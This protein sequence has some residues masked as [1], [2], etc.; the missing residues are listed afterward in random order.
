[1]VRRGLLALIV[2][3]IGSMMLFAGLAAASQ[4]T[5]IN[6]ANAPSGTHLQ[7]GTIG[8]SVDATTQLV[9]CNSF[10]LNGV[11]NANAIGSLVATYSA[12]VN[13]TNHGGNLVPVKSSAQSAPTTTGSLSPKNGSLVVP[14]LNSGPV[15]SAAQFEKQA[16]CP[17]GNW[18]KSL[19][20]GSIALSSFTYTLS[21]PKVST[22][23]YITITG[24]DP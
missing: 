21:F 3:V 2:S 7:S 13:C 24:N 9:T 23:A 19:Q 1:M 4:T 18:T 14:S 15:P 11:G 5:T 12:T 20:G 17:N 6:P 8:C 22:G 16:T 10:Q